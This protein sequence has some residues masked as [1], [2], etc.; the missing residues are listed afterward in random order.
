MFSWDEYFVPMLRG[1]MVRR[2]QDG[3]PE[4]YRRS[5][6]KQD[7]AR[8][9]KKLAAADMGERSLNRPSGYRK[10]ENKLKKRQET[11]VKLKNAQATSD[12]LH[13]PAGAWG[14][15]DR[16]SSPVVERLVS[17]DKRDTKGAKV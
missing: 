7:L 10:E 6:I 12:A 9:E 4:D 8:Y 2:A 15:E 14:K 3:Y 5:V 13:K 16:E 17:I 1:Y 11:M